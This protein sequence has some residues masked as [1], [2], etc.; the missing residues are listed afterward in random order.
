MNTDRDLLNR[1]LDGGLGPADLA[2]LNERLREEAALR[3]QLE[4]S[5][6]LRAT[7]S[8][9]RA[10]SFAPYFSDRVMRRLLPARAAARTEA[11]YESLRATFTRT[12]V[13]GLILAAALAAFNFATYG[14]SDVVS[15]VPEALFG[16]PSASL[17]DAL[18]YPTF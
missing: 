4:A 15:S 7:I 10:D 13:A 1:Y 9:G 2:R 12:A 18:S 8:L 5:K 3:E 6:R 17:V 16:L 11:F 14:D